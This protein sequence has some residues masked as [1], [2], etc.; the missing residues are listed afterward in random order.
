LLFTA[1]AASACGDDGSSSSAKIEGCLDIAEVIVGRGA[2]CRSTVGTGA[3][4]PVLIATP[5][6]GLLL[7]PGK[8]EMLYQSRDLGGSWQ[9]I[10]PTGK[11]A[12]K[13][14]RL[15]PYLHRDAAMG[16]IYFNYFNLGRGA[17]ECP[18]NSGT[19]L[20]F[21]DDDGATWKGRSVGCGSHDWAKV[22]TGPAPT[23]ALAAA[24]QSSGAKSVVYLCATGPTLIIGPDHMC[25]RSSDGG[26]SFVATRAPGAN[27][28]DSPE[29]LHP[30]AFPQAGVVASDGF[31][32][33]SHATVEGQLAL[34]VSRDGGDSW[35]KKPVPEAQLAGGYTN[36]LSSNLAIDSEDS[37]YLVWV[38]DRDLLP[39][40]SISRDRGAT[41]SA[42]TK[43][44]ADEVKHGAYPNVAVFAPGHIAVA[45]YGSPSAEG[46]GDGY[47]SPDGR[48]YHAYLSVSKQTT[49][50]P[51]F[52]T[53]RINAED[54]PVVA[55]WS[56]PTSEYLGPPVLTSDGSVWA[57]YVNTS[58]T[59]I[60][61][62][63]L[64]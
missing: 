52:V 63:A 18:D 29:P 24:L 54:A 23:P 5:N 14:S 4:D 55:S 57:A 50:A 39:Y 48:P 59:L 62:L 45:Y 47:S 22:I 60:G 15:H 31:I 30:I 49:G 17:P 42:R 10:D 56:F 33:K 64:P 13:G 44:S 21:S 38:D 11:G 37:L 25:Y 19:N 26:D 2:A 1:F 27:S 53:A 58:S 28:V 40:L 36:F 34:K 41:W 20:W 51:S 16:R 43:L 7:S 46:T 32:Y 9:P 35:E 12:D 6:D 3:L 61:R 8:G